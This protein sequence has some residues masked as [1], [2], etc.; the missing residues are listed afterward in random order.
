MFSEN[1]IW[2]SCVTVL[3]DIIW[4]SIS[5]AVIGG[6]SQFWVPVC[7][8]IHIYLAVYG[9]EIMVWLQEII[10]LARGLRFLRIFV[11]VIQ[12]ELRCSEGCAVMYQSN[13]SFNIPPGQPPGICIFCKIFVQIP[14]SR[15]R[16]A[17][18]M[19]HHRFIPGD[20]MP[21]PPGNFSVAFV[22]L[23]KLCM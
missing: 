17:V 6:L 10:N 1:E 9:E 7:G 11:A 14:P 23:R 12:T 3:P 8:F 2:A 4:G 16:K 21:P 5:L 13:R 20:Q 18:Q 19:P 22:M 15:G